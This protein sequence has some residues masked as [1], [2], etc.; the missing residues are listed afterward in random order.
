MITVFETHFAKPYCTAGSVVVIGNFDGVHYGHQQIL[1]QAK[2]FAQTHNLNFCVL[3]F[4]PHPVQVLA[5]Q[6]APL[7]IQTTEQKISTL[8]LLGVDLIVLQKFDILF[9]Q[10]SPAE[11]FNTHLIQNL[12]AKAVFVGYDFTFGQKRSGTTETLEK[13]AQ[14]HNTT[15]SVIPAQMLGH[16]LVSSTLIRK[17]LQSGNVKEAN[18][19]LT[20]PYTIEGQVIPGFKRGTA[21]GIHTAN[22]K[23]Q[24]DLLLND[25][26]YATKAHY[27]D[28]IYNSVTNIGF[29]PTFENTNRSIETHIF[30]FNHQIYSENLRLD[31]MQ[32]LRNEIKFANQTALVKQIEIDI[33][34]AQRVLNQTE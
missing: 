2:N 10:I 13:L 21:L 7:S 12:N 11:F 1:L 30:N 6:F 8:K 18:H 22:L 32:K 23:S 19:Y 5:P 26:V 16:V 25:G 29:N 4:D 27:K 20:R 9:S 31:F 17:L 34:E 14:N 33:A 15:I 28:Q 24:N 3:S